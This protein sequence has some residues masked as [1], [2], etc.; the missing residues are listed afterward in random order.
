MQTKP[1]RVLALN[2]EYPPI[3]GGGGN[4]HQHI[5]RELAKMPAIDV[6]L[7]TTT[8]K[9]EP[10]T[11]TYSDNVRIQFLPIQKQSLHYWK[12]GEVI[13]YLIAHH[14]YLKQHLKEHTYD[15]CHVFFGFPTGLLAYLHRKK[16]PYI[17]SVRGSDVPGY[18]K[19]FSLDYIILRPILNRVYHHAK[20]VIANSRQFADLFE[21]QFPELSAEV[22]TNGIDT[23]TFQ[24]QEHY[25]DVMKIVTAA[26]LIPRKGIDILIKACKQLKKNNILFEL[27]I[28]GEGPEEEPLK[29]LCHKLHIASQVNFLG[30]VERK[31]MQTL[32]PQCD[33]FVLPSY[34]E[35]MSNA[36]LEA[37]ACG[38]PLILTNTGGTKELINHNG[39]IIP[40][41]DDLMLADKLMDLCE[42]KT[43]RQQM[44]EQSRQHARSYSWQKIAQQYYDVYR[45]VMSD[46]G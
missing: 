13:R 27:N 25:N 18:N 8:P 21:E 26:R 23:E 1:L 30:R 15:L 2:Y 10:Y 14:K 31:N 45:Q 36:A 3:G 42:D 37:L 35:G 38:L 16:M 9:A 4:A 34:A 22:I 20:A 24:P 40:F 11:E 41:G 43:L 33:V 12:R 6:T 32:L 7:I 17:V 28:A 46:V 5:L 39:F 44:G 29:Q 19:R